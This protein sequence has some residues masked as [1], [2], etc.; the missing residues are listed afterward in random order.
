MSNSA[1]LGQLTGDVPELKDKKDEEAKPIELQQYDSAWVEVKLAAGKSAAKVEG[2]GKDLAWRAAEAG[3]DAAKKADAK[4]GSSIR[5]H[6]TREL[7]A[8]PG[9][10]DLT[11]LDA[12]GKPIA[13][14]QIAVSCTA[15]GEKA[16]K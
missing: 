7:T 13:S 9:T 10:I 15:C 2:D 6:V 8:K 4:G 1:G 11:V 14:Q 16:D 5:V 3:A 12:L